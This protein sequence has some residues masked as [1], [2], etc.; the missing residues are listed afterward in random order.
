MSSGA[1]LVLTVGTGSKERLEE[2]LYTPLTKSIRDGKWREV[3]LLPS[4]A[5]EGGAEV[6]KKRFPDLRIKMRSLPNSDMENDADACFAYFNSV[7]GELLEEYKREE[8]LIDFTRDTKG[9][10]VALVLAAIRH[11]IPRMRYIGG[12]RDNHGAVIA[13]KEEIANLNAVQ[14]TGRRLLDDARHLLR[15]ATLPQ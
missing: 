3:V 12:S 1:V 10:R 8:V 13:G 7:L 15:K 9:M 11:N 2:T 14:A 4:R 6:L 5:T